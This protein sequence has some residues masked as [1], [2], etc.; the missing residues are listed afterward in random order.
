M[1]PWRSL[2]LV[3]LG[4]A[5]KSNWWFGWNG[6][7][8]SA[9]KDEQLLSTHHPDIHDWVIGKLRTPPK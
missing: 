2:K 7:R 4:K 1:E 8:L 5:K 3:R 9:S 6:N